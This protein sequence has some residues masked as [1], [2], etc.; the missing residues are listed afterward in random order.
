MKQKCTVKLTDVQL[1][2]G[3]RQV[4]ELTAQGRF[5][6]SEGTYS[7]RFEEM[8]DE[9]VRSE[10]TV[11]ALRPGCVTVVHRGDITTDL[12]VELGKRH[13]SHY[14]TPYCELMIGIDALAI[15]DNMT[16]QGGSLK[17]R[18]SIDYFAAAAAMKEITIEVIL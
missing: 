1:E 7:L 6:W 9:G 14:I 18:Y 11:T 13:V 2:E 8:F 17:L 3:E 5:E 16:E 10:T 4:V 15:E 12:T